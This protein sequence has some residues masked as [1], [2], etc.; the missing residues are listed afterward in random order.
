MS[1]YQDHFH[2]SENFISNKLYI[3]LFAPQQQLAQSVLNLLASDR[4]ELK[5]LSLAQ[6]LVNFIIEHKEQIDCIIFIKNN[7]QENVLQNLCQAQI[8]LP[9]LI[10]ESDAV[11]LMADDS[12]NFTANQTLYHQAEIHLY[13]TQLT[14]INAYIKL[15]I[16]KFLNLASKLNINSGQVISEPLAENPHTSLVLQQH[17]LTEKLK[18]R[19]GYLG[20]YYKRNPNQFYRNLSSEKQ[21]ELGQQ[22]SKNYRQILID[23]FRDNSAINDLIDEFVALA[24]FADV[25]TSFILE[26]HMELIDAFSQQLKIE[27]RSEDILLDYRL[28]L[29]DILAHLCEMYRRSIPGTN[30]SLELLYK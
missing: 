2:S 7:D 19:L 6:D 8:L 23:Y 14:E 20:I 16:S 10:L 18:K 26:I 17:K 4:Y 12:T 21:K 30:I 29:I 13:P 11:G 1:D 9:T 24:F 5:C 15:A 22:L 28:P 3:C 25:S 27:G